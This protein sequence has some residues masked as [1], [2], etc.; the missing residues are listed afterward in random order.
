[1][2]ALKLYDRVCAECSVLTT[3]AYSTSFSLGIRFLGKPLRE[4]IYSIYGYVRFADEIVDTF[5]HTDKAVLFDRFKKDTDLALKE[6]ISLNPILHAFQKVYN[7]YSLD[8]EHVNLFLQSMEWDLNR[9]DY[10]RKHFEQYIVGSAEVVGLMCLKVFVGG[11]QTEYDRL[12]PFAERLGAAFQ[13]IN[14]L[15]DLKADYEE[16]GRSYFPNLDMSQFDEQTKQLI[17][18]EI[19]ADF[20]EAY[21]GIIQLPRSCRLGVY[22][23]YIYYLRLFQKIRSLPSE[24]IMEE[25]IRIPN[26]RKAT[27]FVGSYLRHSFNML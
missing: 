10:D 21:K 11:N 4:P 18:D 3:K 26:T 7:K 2:D 17:E 25:R 9:A 19:E 23:A 27:L 22:I 5:H 20:Q 6:G 13:K 12:R 8:K 14:F 15:R 24:R 16:M 1:M